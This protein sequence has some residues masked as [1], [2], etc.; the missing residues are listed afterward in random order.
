MVNAINTRLFRV[1]YEHQLR[2]QMVGYAEVSSVRIW[3]LD[4]PESLAPERTDEI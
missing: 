1:G 4:E 3:C 2:C